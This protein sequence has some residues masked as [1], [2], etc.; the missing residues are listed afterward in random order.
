MS[1]SRASHEHLLKI[2]SMLK[3]HYDEA[4]PDRDEPGLEFITGGAPSRNPRFC[5][6]R[7]LESSSSLLFE[8]VTRSDIEEAF[9]LWLGVSNEES[10]SSSNASSPSQVATLEAEDYDSSDSESENEEEESTSH[11]LH[12][13]AAAHGDADHDPSTSSEASPRKFVYVETDSSS[14]DTDD[15]DLSDDDWRPS[16]LPSPRSKSSLGSPSP[17]AAALDDDYS[18]L[19]SLLDDCESKPR[20]EQDDEAS[21]SVDVCG[22]P[23][24]ETLFDV[25]GTPSELAADGIGAGFADASA[26]D[27]SSSSSLSS[28]EANQAS[29][30]S[31]SVRGQK[32]RRA[33]EDEDF[34]G[35]GPRTKRKSA[36]EA[37]GKGRGSFR[38]T[39]DDCTEVF[40]TNSDLKRHIESSEAHATRAFEC[41]GCQSAFVRA[42]AFCRH[43]QSEKH[44][45]CRVVLCVKAKMPTWTATMARDMLQTCMV[46]HTP[47]AGPSREQ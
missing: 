25:E 38:C 12:E 26:Q 36:R 7:W 47:K 41:P 6:C 40:T 5:Y 42:E 34:A 18:H 37:K 21:A 19:M 14:S 29:I 16:L 20:D 46:P 43:F 32:R 30:S 31:A 3:S 22:S 44:A 28:V 8:G 2:I 10:E 45:D 11:Q 4:F 27:C 33:D 15:N 24:P 13:A 39:L 9:S 17:P 1:A 23:P 35:A